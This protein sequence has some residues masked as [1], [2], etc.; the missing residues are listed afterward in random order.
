MQAVPEQAPI[1]M[2]YVQILYRAAAVSLT[3]AGHQPRQQRRCYAVCT[4]TSRICYSR[5][6]P[7]AP[8]ITAH[9]CDTN[10]GS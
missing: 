1:P 10:P 4:C 3:V 2:D 9:I 6:L 5:C 7:C 8:H